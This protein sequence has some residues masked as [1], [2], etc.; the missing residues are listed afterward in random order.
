MYHRETGQ[1]TIINDPLGAHPL[2]IVELEGHVAFSSEYQII[3]K[4]PY[5]NKIVNFEAIR[6]FLQYRL[7]IDGKTPI[8]GLN[9]LASGSVFSW[10]GGIHKSMQRYED[11][12]IKVDKTIKFEDAVHEIF[13]TMSASMVKKLSDKKVKFIPLTGG[14]DTRVIFSL[15]PQDIRKE[16]TWQTNLSPFLQANEDR[17]VIIASKLTANYKLNHSISKTPIQKEESVVDESWLFESTRPTEEWINVNGH[18]PLYFRD[19]N[20]HPQQLEIPRNQG[21]MDSLDGF[22]RRRNSGTIDVLSKRSADVENDNLPFFN[23]YLFKFSSILCDLP[24]SAGVWVNPTSIMLRKLR[25]PFIDASTY[26]ALLSLPRSYLANGKLYLHLIKRGDPRLI[27]VPFAANPFAM[28]D[29]PIMQ[30]FKVLDEGRDYSVVRKKIWN[31]IL[32]RYLTSSDTNKRSLYSGATL[33]KLRLKYLLEFSSL[34]YATGFIR[35]H[36]RYDTMFSSSAEHS[37][38]VLESWLRT[39]L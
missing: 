21:F 17:D 10:K 34:R 29:D 20:P 13:N 33:W 19:Q 7:F 2:F 4:L 14:I 38:V 18:F 23:I 31:K 37:F 25:N 11:W 30:D 24:P 9:N 35:R 15:I 16:F 5:K 27:Q 26:R 28:L 3:S 39:Y 22:D 32:Y 36:W 6:E 8:V 1:L 12:N